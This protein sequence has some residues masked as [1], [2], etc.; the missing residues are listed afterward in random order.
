MPNSY[1]NPGNVEATEG[2]AGDTGERYGKNDRFAVFDS[3]EMGL[4]ALF[5]DIKTKIKK[6]YDLDKLMKVYAPPSE[7][8]TD[9]YTKYV[10]E[11]VGK[12]KID[13]DDVDNIVRGIVEFENMGYGQEFLDQY[14]NE[15]TFAIA[16]ELSDYDLPAGT[17]YSDALMI[18]PP[19]EQYPDLDERA[20][21]YVRP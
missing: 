13:M 7:N 18:L 14:L 15:D 9:N 16:K 3:P 4:R 12:N 8:P 19:D 11:R 2:W 5:R 10:K 20:F 17:S 1:Y 21:E 6:G